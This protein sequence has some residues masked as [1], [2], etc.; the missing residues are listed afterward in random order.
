MG[1]ASSENEPQHDADDEQE[2]DD[3]H[4]PSVAI[5]STA[6]AAG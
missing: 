3:F 6:L 5:L 1:L 4:E 2:E